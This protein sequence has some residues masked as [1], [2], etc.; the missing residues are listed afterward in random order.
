MRGSLKSVVIGG[1]L[2][3]V[4]MTCDP[5]PKSPS[6]SS[7]IIHRILIMLSSILPT[8]MVPLICLVGVATAMAAFF[9]YVEGDAA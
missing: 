8:I 9:F 7:F 2:Y 1:W 4:A 3:E 6:N 5:L